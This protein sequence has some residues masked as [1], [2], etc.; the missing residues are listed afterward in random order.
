MKPVA[1]A[2]LS[3][4]IEHECTQIPWGLFVMCAI[5]LLRLVSS[6]WTRMDD[7]LR[8]GGDKTIR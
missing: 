5:P 2:E 4:A 3:A 6:V 8:T 7:N 1:F